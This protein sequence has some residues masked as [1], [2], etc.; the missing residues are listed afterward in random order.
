M[1]ER[2]RGFPGRTGKK[3]PHSKRN[4]KKPQAEGKNRTAPFKNVKKGKTK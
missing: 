1:V 2:V 4:E 3:P